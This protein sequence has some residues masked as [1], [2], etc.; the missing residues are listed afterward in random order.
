MTRNGTADTAPHYFDNSRGLPTWCGKHADQLTAMDA[1]RI[2]NFCEV[3]A[4]R[5]GW[6]AEKNGIQVDPMAM[7]FHPEFLDG[8]PYHIWRNC[9]EWGRETYQRETATEPA[10]KVDGP[11]QGEI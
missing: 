7:L 6:N 5:Q 2:L 11:D 3:E 8:R 10:H 4:R 9:F 1:M